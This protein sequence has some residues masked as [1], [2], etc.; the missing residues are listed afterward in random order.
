MDIQGYDEVLA[1]NISYL[2][3]SLEGSG[4]YN[5]LIR[6]E[7]G[8]NTVYELIENVEHRDKINITS[9]I[10]DDN[11]ADLLSMLLAYWKLGVDKFNFAPIMYYSPFEMKP[12]K[13]LSC[14]SL[15]GFVSLCLDFMNNDNSLDAIDIRICMTKA[16]AY[17]LFLKENILTGKI[18][19]YI[20]RGNKMKYQRGIR[21][22]SLVILYSAFHSLMNWSL[23]MMVT[24]YPVQ[25]IF[26][27]S[28]LIRSLY[29]T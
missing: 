21:C 5:D 23:L 28:I 3:I 12:L 15:L 6:G 4:K 16:M 10:F 18:E 11:G 8:Y 24:L 27:I 25:M 1:T 13:S 26:I 14:E 19:E 17:E 2:E 20:Y 29:R 7:N 22:W 9:T